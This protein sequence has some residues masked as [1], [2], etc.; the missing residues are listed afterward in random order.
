MLSPTN[1]S[2]CARFCPFDLWAQLGWAFRNILGGMKALSSLAG[3]DIISHSARKVMTGSNPY[4][5]N[6]FMKALL[7]PWSHI[8]PGLQSLQ[9]QGEPQCIPP[10]HNP[11]HSTILM[12]LPAY[13]HPEEGELVRKRIWHQWHF[14]NRLSVYYSSLKT[15][16]NLHR[17]PEY[18][19]VTGCNYVEP[20]K[21]LLSCNDRQSGL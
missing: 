19:T 16:I 7:F 10:I 3:H 6:A 15:N 21:K 1:I 8:I 12:G 4:W 13:R 14:D 18:Q 5:I 9:R 17:E 20:A 2:I 11:T